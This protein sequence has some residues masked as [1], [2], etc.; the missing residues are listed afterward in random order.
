M[1]VYLKCK[2]FTVSN[3]VFELKKHKEFDMLFTSPQPLTE[4][5]GAYYK[6]EKYISHTDASDHFIDK[7]YQMVKKIAI[8]SKVKSI[9]TYK[10]ESKNLLDVGCGTGEFLL[11][12]KNDGWNVVGVEPNPAAKTLTIS[13]IKNKN[14]VF[15]S[16]E[17]V[18]KASVNKKFDVIT[19]WH[20]LEHVPN[21]VETIKTLSGLLSENGIL[22]IAV[23]NFKSF[24]AV[25]YKEYWAAFDVPRH[26][27]H[28]SRTAIESLFMKEGMFLSKYRPMWFDS[29]YVS[30][31]S[32]TH[33]RGKSN[34]LMAFIIG[35]Y[36]N[37]KGVFTKEV[38]SIIYFLEKKEV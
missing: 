36:S 9:K 16:L 30:M 22:L 33:K 32:E 8:K 15:D 31:L 21:L 4:D 34:L 11:A 20:V 3:E 17:A 19:M 14:I 38:S 6:S 26:L 25:Y 28:F 7:V 27:W 24:D 29:F 1:S 10:K 12:C 18:K 23:P 5:L 2:D 35:F 13:K 37:L